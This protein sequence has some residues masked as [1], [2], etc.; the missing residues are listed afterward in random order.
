MLGIA[1]GLREVGWA[2]TDVLV[3][4]TVGCDSLFQSV[5]KN[6]LV[7]LPAIT[8]V[9]KSLGAAQ[10]SPTAFDLTQQWKREGKSPRVTSTTVTDD[11]ALDACKNFAN[12]HRALVEPACGACLAL[13][14][15]GR[16]R[17]AT[18]D[19]NDAGCVVVQVCGGAI[20]DLNAFSSSSSS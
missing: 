15:E 8:S 16:V 13:S 18:N 6:E 10:V 14:Y 3:S 19:T 5:Q 4:E 2:K 20:T 17:D 11:Q 7:T 12:H 9:A 1:Q